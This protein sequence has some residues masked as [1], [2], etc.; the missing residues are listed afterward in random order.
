[1]SFLD[2]FVIPAL[3]TF[4]LSPT[5]AY[6]YNFVNQ[7]SCIPLDGAVGLNALDWTKVAL[8]LMLLVS[9]DTLQLAVFK[10]SCLNSF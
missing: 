5:V 3:H 10:V 6:I 9:Y 8:V 7:L 1:M 2:R 4:I